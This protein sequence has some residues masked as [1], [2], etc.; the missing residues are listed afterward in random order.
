MWAEFFTVV[1]SFAI[2]WLL[3]GPARE[4]RRVLGIG[5]AL[6]N[7]GLGALI[8]TSSF[9]TPLVASTVITYFVIQLVVTT[10]L[11]MYFTRT[12]K[13]AMA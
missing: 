4:N 9:A 3:G 5:T 11:G 7:I 6:R 13:E 10:I 8:A 1:L 2:G 12:A